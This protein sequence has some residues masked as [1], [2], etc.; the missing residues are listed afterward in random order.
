MLDYQQLIVLM[1]FMLLYEN[2]FE[3]ALSY[4]W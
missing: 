4:N 3:S 2:T 1:N